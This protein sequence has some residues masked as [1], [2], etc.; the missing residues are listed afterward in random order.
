MLGA[1]LL[2]VKLI[3][4]P[5]ATEREG[6]IEALQRALPDWPIEVMAASDGV[7]W[8]ANPEVLK[9]HPWTG[10]RISR[11]NIGCTQSHLLL[12]R[13]AVLARKGLILFEDDAEII[14]AGKG[15]NE[16]VSHVQTLS[17]ESWD[18]I[19]LGATEY[20]TSH[21][22]DARVARVRRFWG[23]HAMIVSLRAAEAAL[24]AFDVYQREGKFPPADWLYNRAIADAQLMVYGPTLPKQLCQQAPGLVSA[25]TGKTR[26]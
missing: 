8:D 4:L 1:P 25:I 13:E 14:V 9:A 7:A 23:T 18:I 12:L 11:G 22:I 20:V 17:G 19:L 24:V 21:P 3:H 26:V 16:F 2:G 5:T 15:V 6:H 10:E